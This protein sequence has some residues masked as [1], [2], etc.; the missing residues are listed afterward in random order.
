MHDEE[1]IKKIISDTVDAT[2]QR[3]KEAGLLKDAQDIAYHEITARLRQYYRDGETDQEVMEALKLIEDD[4]YYKI[5]PLVFRYG[6][7][8]EAVAETFGVDVST[9]TRNKKRLSLRVQELLKG[10]S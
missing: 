7:T 8:L 3:L 5:I 9:V 10:E 6:Y 2:I 1:K 4:E